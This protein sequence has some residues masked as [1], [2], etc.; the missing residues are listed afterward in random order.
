MLRLVA[1]RVDRKISVEYG[2]SHAIGHARRGNLVRT[3][4]ILYILLL[5][6]KG[7]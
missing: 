4:Y 5:L 7:S 3:V 2:L 6:T 1:L